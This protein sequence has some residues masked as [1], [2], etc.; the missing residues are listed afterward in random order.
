MRHVIQ[1]AATM[2]LVALVFSL[3]T[4]SDRPTGEDPILTTC[5]AFC[6]NEERCYPGITPGD[7]NNSRDEQGCLEECLVFDDWDGC[8]DETHTSL[9]CRSRL[10]CEEYARQRAPDTSARPCHTESRAADLCRYAKNAAA[11]SR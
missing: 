5:E 6:A 10:S 8:A 11:A 7:Y 4:C 9:Q 1:V 2:T 3:V